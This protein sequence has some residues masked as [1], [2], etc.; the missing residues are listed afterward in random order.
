MNVYTLDNSISSHI[1]PYY[2]SRC[3]MLAEYREDIM[4]LGLF[5]AIALNILNHAGNNGVREQVQKM[6]MLYLQKVPCK[7]FD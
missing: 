4:K 3:R 2:E 5:D 6:M 1:G 7:K